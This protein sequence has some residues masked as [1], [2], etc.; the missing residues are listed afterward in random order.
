MGQSNSSI[1][2]QE[3]CTGQWI[4]SNNVELIDIF[5]DVGKSA[6]TFERPD[7]IS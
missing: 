2:A 4:S 7:F 6:K 3:L 1:E 5:I